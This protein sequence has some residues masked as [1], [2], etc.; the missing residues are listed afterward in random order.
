MLLSL[1]PRI[2]TK[3][4]KGA[5]ESVERGFMTANHTKG[6]HGHR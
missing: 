1:G 3:A 6:L 2:Q 4:P 5:D